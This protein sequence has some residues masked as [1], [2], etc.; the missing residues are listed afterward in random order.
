M[1]S[2]LLTNYQNPMKGKAEHKQPVSDSN[3]KTL[4]FKPTHE[5]QMVKVTNTIQAK[6]L[7]RKAGAVD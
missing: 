6:V 1:C 5:K 4:I 7:S 2:H 3:N